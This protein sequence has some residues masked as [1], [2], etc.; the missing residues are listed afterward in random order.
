M[1]NERKIEILQQMKNSI[2]NGGQFMCN[3][4]HNIVGYEHEL[5]ED[6]PEFLEYGGPN[7]MDGCTGL[8]WDYIILDGKI[9]L[10]WT[11]S[12]PPEHIHREIYKCQTFKEFCALK[13]K[14]IDK[15][16]RDLQNK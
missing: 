1:T 2:Q 8:A 7:A 6:M 10:G 5:F 4:Y 3:I 11:D 14:V 16:I 9:Y 13:L 15:V 12:I